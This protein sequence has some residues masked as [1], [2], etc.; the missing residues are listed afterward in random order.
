[1]LIPED[2]RLSL[3]VSSQVGCSL[4]C[5]F[6]HTGTQ[7]IKRNLTHS[8]ILAQYLTAQSFV[9]A[10]DGY[11]SKRITNVVFMGQG[12]PLYNFKYQQTILLRLLDFDLCRNVRNAI[13]FMAEECNLG[14]GKITLSTSGIAPAIPQIA[15]DPGCM[16]AV[17]LH[18]ANNDL[19][20]SIMPINKT[21][22]LE[23]LIESIKEFI[24]NA[25][26]ARK[27]VTF[28]YVMLNGVNDRVE[29]AKELG[30]L[31]RA[32][33]PH[34]HINLI[35]FNKWPGAPYE[36]TPKRE[37]LQFSKLVATCY[38]IPTTVRTTRGQDIMAA[39]G[40]LNTQSHC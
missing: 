29:D 4:S 13:K 40:Q 9:N 24:K 21:Y 27:R 15:S 37:M 16:L 10:T 38:H 11:P 33:A 30:E 3:C 23:T 6:C 25:S 35:P 12:E 1:M 34:A 31:L 17:S 7:R 28:E 8:E 32:L 2:D 36:A 14:L 22:P 5:T 19:R 39:C 18:A 20:S 26:C